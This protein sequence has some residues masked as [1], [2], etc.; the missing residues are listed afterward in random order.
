MKKLFSIILCASFLLCACGQQVQEESL[1]VSNTNDYY[2]ACNRTIEIQ[3]K[4]YNL[5]KSFQREDSEYDSLNNFWEDAKYFYLNFS[6]INTEALE[7]TYCYNEEQVSWDEAVALN[8]ESWNVNEQETVKYNHEGKHQYSYIV[9]D[10][11]QHKPYFK[12][13]YT[14]VN[15]KAVSEYI[16]DK[17]WMSTIIYDSVDGENAQTNM[18]EYAR[19][20]NGAVFQTDNERCLVYFRD[21]WEEVVIPV[22]K[23]REKTYTDNK[24]KTVTAYEQYVEEVP[25]EHFLGRGISE[26]YYSKLVEGTRPKYKDEKREYID[27]LFEDADT[28]A[29]MDA[30]IQKLNDFI[31]LESSSKYNNKMLSNK[32]NET[33]YLAMHYNED[34][35]L[36]P[37]INE[38]NKNWVISDDEVYEQTVVYQNGKI[39][40]SYAN[41]LS[42]KTSKVY[43]DKDDNKQFSDFETPYVKEFTLEDMYEILEEKRELMLELQNKEFEQDSDGESE[44]DEL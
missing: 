25:M 12:N 3:E 28:S 23:T 38:I 14:N 44:D 34:E 40:L 9:P 4:I 41:N 32:G 43:V 1:T 15:R 20:E 17:D 26:L 7:H 6:P 29:K 13:E 11:S 39:E 27:S 18:F 16:P 22:L 21:E 35:S 8:V 24:G 2:G 5:T 42:G 10:L 30:A 19:I 31:T 33:S 37:I 36:F